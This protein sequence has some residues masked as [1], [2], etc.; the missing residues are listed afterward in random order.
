VLVNCVAPGLIE[1]TRMAAR[2]PD[3][4]REGALQRA[5]LRRAASVDDIADQVVTFCRSDSTTGQ[6]LPVDAGGVFH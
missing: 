1:G 5:V 4:I 6:V 3:A 2:L